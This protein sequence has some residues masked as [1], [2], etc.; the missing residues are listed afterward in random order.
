MT[1]TEDT[2]WETL[3]GTCQYG[4][5]KWWNILGFKSFGNISKGV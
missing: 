5:L 1:P 4:L 3:R 2:D